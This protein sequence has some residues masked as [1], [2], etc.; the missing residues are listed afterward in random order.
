MNRALHLAVCAALLLAAMV[1]ARPPLAQVQALPSAA[2]AP[3]SA[4]D[5]ALPGPLPL[6][7]EE[8]DG[9]AGPF[10]WRA[11]TLL[12]LAGGAG[13][14]L[15]WRRG[16]LVRAAAGARS[17]RGAPGV[18]RLA[19]QALTPQASVHSLRWHGEELLLG[20]T[21]QQVTLLARHRMDVPEE[22]RA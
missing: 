19:S 11:L 9:P 5:S 10:G 22:E 8:Q 16:A 4:R 21:A 3:A 20:C 12:L 6:R 13:G 1:P 7:R 2:G 17:L 15:L 14:W 18:L